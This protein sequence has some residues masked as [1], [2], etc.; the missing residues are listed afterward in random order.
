MN[1]IGVFCFIY[2]YLRLVSINQTAQRRMWHVNRC[3]LRADPHITVGG[4]GSHWGVTKGTPVEV[5]SPHSW[6]QMSCR[7]KQ[8]IIKVISSRAAVIDRVITALAFRTTPHGR[9]LLVHT[10]LLFVVAG[11]L[12]QRSF[13]GIG[14]F[15]FLSVEELMGY[16]NYCNYYFNKVTTVTVPQVLT[17]PAT[18][19][20]PIDM[21]LF[22]VGIFQRLIHFCE[23]PS[24]TIN[25]WGV[26]TS[27]GTCIFFYH[28][29]TL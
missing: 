23:G 10:Q 6:K 19:T 18:N 3:S 8:L 25:S 11:F 27:H 5:H 12:W 7:N 2:L 20:E 14:I 28:L 13:C 17:V 24:V 21:E 22:E 15:D 26:R 9:P 16:C 4:G 1:I 29:V